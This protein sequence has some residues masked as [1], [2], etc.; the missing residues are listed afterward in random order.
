VLTTPQSM[1]ALVNGLEARGLTART[2]PRLRGV[3]APLTITDA[4]RAALRRTSPAIRQ[5]EREV[6]AGLPDD[7]IQALRLVRAQLEERLEL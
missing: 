5:M 4:G 3:A 1:A 6:F 7:R 2:G